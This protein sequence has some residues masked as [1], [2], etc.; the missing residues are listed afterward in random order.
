MD[1]RQLALDATGG[2]QTALSE[3]WT[4]LVPVSHSIAKCAYVRGRVSR[5]NVDDVSQEILLAVPKLVSTLR[6]K[7]TGGRFE[8]DITGWIITS[9]NYE[10]LHACERLRTIEFVSLNTGGKDGEPIDLTDYGYEPADTATC[11]KCGVD[12]TPLS[13]E[14]DRVHCGK[15]YNKF[16]RTIKAVKAAV[17]DCRQ[18]LAALRNGP[19]HEKGNKRTLALL[20]VAGYKLAFDKQATTIRLKST[21]DDSTSFER[22]IGKAYLSSGAKLNCWCCG[23][24]FE[25]NI[26][27]ANNYCSPRCNLRVKENHERRQNKVQAKP[28]S[29]GKSGPRRGGSGRQE[30]RRLRDDDGQ[31]KHQETK[32]KPRSKPTR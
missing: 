29:S 25:F 4:A 31:A 20:R 22:R 18:L 12:L 14:R 7:I 15:C 5:W 19:V 8:F 27:N 3:L 1:L 16:E 6:Q 2:S 30:V 11:V 23:S 32:Q 9:L 10:S 21:P 17:E 26:V 24:E 13:L 28:P